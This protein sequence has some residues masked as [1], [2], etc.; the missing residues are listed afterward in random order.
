MRAASQPYIFDELT[1]WRLARLPTIGAT[2]A[3]LQAGIDQQLILQ[4]LFIR[5]SH[6]LFGYGQL[7]TRLPALTGF[8]IMMLGLYVFL[9]RR[10][11]ASYALVG[12]LLPT[13]TFAW[14]FAFQARAY[15]PVLG[16]AAIALVAWQSAAADEYRPFALPAITLSL[17]IALASH[18]GAVMLAIPLV[19]GEVVRS[20]RRRPHR[21]PDVDLLRCRGSRRAPLSADS[22][23]HQELGRHRNAA[24][25]FHNVQLL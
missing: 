6:S 23:A 4:P 9:R 10:L 17:A 21:C 22:G 12:M 18:M 14:G 1:S 11:P 13:L 19:A 8:W 15:G 3:A 2:W 16:C 5:F 20:V 7:A 24:R 25:Y